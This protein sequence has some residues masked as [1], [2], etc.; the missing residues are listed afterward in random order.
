MVIFLIKYIIKRIFVI[1][2]III[3]V[4][5]IACMM[6]NIMPGDAARMIA[7]D[8]ASEEDIASI[9]EKYGLDQPIIQQ[10]Y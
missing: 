3:V 2:P 10:Y 1:I 4:S 9:R 8:L 7:G 6:V 5:F